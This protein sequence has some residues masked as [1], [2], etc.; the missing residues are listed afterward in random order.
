M[1]TEIS[2]YCYPS[3]Q[4]PP[5]L[6]RE[7]ADVFRNHESAIS[8]LELSQGDSLKSDE[9]LEKVRPE[10]EDVGFEVESGSRKEDRVRRAVTFGESGEP[11]RSHDV[12]G[13]HEGEKCVLEVEAGRAWDSNHAHRNLVRAMTMP[14]VELLAMAV[15]RKYKHTNSTT[16]A[17]EK[18]KETAEALYGNGRV[19]LP[20]GLILLGY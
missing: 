6:A 8:T 1:A 4:Q 3:T 5:E 16:K 19:D 7:I 12:D 11:N 18:S 13:Y 17:F 10:L 9:V 20:F 2:Y 14:D 15:P